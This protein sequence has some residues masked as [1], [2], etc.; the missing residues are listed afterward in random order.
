VNK[1]IPLA[2]LSTDLAGK[3][4][5][6]LSLEAKGISTSSIENR[7]SLWPVVNPLFIS[8]TPNGLLMATSP[9]K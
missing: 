5:S 9:S 7:L 1:E 4:F 3:S 8:G 2:N 6:T